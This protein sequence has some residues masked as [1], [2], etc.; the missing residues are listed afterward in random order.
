M[1]FVDFV[2]RHVATIEPLE[3]ESALAYWEAARTG[4]EEDFRRYSELIIELE[5]VYTNKDDFEFISE[6]RNDGALRDEKLKRIADLLYLQYLA[7]QIDHELL[8]RIVELSSSVENRF[9]VSRR[10]SERGGERSGLR[11]LLLDVSY[12]E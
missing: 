1:D 10:A 5:K 11:Q 6:S 4:N 7:N 3:K 9:N 12:R 2:E 8:S